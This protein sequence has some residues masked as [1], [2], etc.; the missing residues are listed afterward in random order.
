MCLDYFQSGNE[1]ISSKLNKLINILL[2]YNNVKKQDLKTI[3]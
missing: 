3:F 2:A 1:V